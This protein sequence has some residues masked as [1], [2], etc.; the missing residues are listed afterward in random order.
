VIG[1]DLRV[2]IYKEYNMSEMI[3]GTKLTKLTIMGNVINTFQEAVS[4]AEYFAGTDLVPK[5]YKGKGANIMVAWQKGSELGLKPLQA[6]S[7]IAV[8]NGRATIWGDGLIA[9]VKNSSKEEWTHETLTGEGDNMVATCETKR[10]NQEKTV[11]QSFSVADA[12][13]AG[14]WGNNTWAKYPKRMLQ[15]RARG[16]CLRDAYP[17]V[18]NGLEI[19]EEMNDLNFQQKTEAKEAPKTLKQLG[20]STSEEDNFLVVVGNT[21]GKQDLLKSLGFVF[22]NNKWCKELPQGDEVID[23]TIDEPEEETIDVS[24]MP[25]AKKKITPAKEL[26]NYLIEKGIEKSRVGEFVKDVLRTSSKD[27][28]GIKLALADKDT[29]DSKIQIFLAEIVADKIEAENLF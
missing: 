5:D 2:L 16:L 4:I 12:K 20:L 11:I 19:A 26:M 10:L 13:K 22:N 7:T 8:V 15:M 6:L 29:L 1:F 27:E 17:D 14:L 28:E 3:K 21:Y 24:P 9:L 18:L 23:V 25:E